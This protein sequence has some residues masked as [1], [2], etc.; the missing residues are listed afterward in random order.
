MGEADMRNQR[1]FRGSERRAE[2]PIWSLGEVRA[3][4]TVTD[5]ERAGEILGIGRTK[6]YELARTDAFPVKVVR[7]GRRYLVPVAGLL[8][9]LDPVDP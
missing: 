7:V 6:A 1:T 4:G 5:I 3:W 2:R 9:I 8:R